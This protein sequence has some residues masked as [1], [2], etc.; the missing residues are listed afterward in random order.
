MP[1]VMT[2]TI[3]FAL[4]VPTRFFSLSYQLKRMNNNILNIYT[5]IVSNSSQTKK[6][7]SQQ[8]VAAAEVR[9]YRQAEKNEE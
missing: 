4:E 1:I 2:R 8:P 5:I 6:T 7:T 9:L 3:L